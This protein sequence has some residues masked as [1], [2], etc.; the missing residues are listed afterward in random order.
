VW[1]L[2]DQDGT[3]EISV[4]PTSRFP[5]T[6][7]FSETVTANSLYDL[8]TKR[9]FEHLYLKFTPAATATVTL[10]YVLGGQ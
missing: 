6:S 2:S 10:A 4:C 5:K 7:W 9:D 3:L 1:L 8:Q